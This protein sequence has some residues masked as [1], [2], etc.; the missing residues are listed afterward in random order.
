MSS[1]YDDELPDI[2]GTK[3][4]WMDDDASRS[5]ENPPKK[6]R[7][8]AVEKEKKKYKST[9][10]KQPM[11]MDVSSDEDFV[12]PGPSRK[13]QTAIVPKPSQEELRRQKGREKIARWRAKQSAK[14]KEQELAANAKRNAATRAN[15]TPEQCLRRNQL[16]AERHAAV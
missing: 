8:S 11:A 13:P 14:E 4:P 10:K 12:E 2:P 5:P 6:P 16:D 9:K 3:F 1:S 7:I 15:E